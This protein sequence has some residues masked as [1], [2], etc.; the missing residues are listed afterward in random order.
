MISAIST[1][2]D[3]PSLHQQIDTLISQRHSE[4]K[5]VPTAI[6][7]DAEFIRRVHLDLNGVIPSAEVTRAFLEN[8]ATDKRQKLIDDL[9][10][11]PDYALHMAR[12]FDVMLTERRIAAGG[13]LYDVPAPNWREYLAESF[14]SNKPWDQLVRELLA[15]DGTDEKLASALKF[16]LVRDVAP[17]QLTRDVGRLFLGVDLQCAQCHDDPHVVDYRQ[18]DYF[19]IYAF[20]ERSKMHPLSPRGAQLAETAASKTTFVSVFTTRSGETSPR[21]PGGE[22]IADPPLEKDKEYLV[23]PEPKV[24]G[25]PTY[26][27]RLKLAEQLPRAGTLGFTRNIANRLWAILLGRGLVHP[28]DLHH[29]ANPPSHPELLAVL[30]RWMVENHYD[31]KGFLREVA[32]SDTYQRSS[33]MPADSKDLSEK[34]F[35]VAPL[36]GLSAEQLRWSVLQATGRIELHYARLDAQTKKTSPLS[37][38]SP[39]PAW[40]EKITRNEALERQSVSLVAAFTGL[41]GQPEEGFQ[42]VVDQ[43][44]Y[45]RNST[46]LLP[47][48][49]ED[50]GTLLARLNQMSDIQSVADGLY[51]SVL[52]RLPTEDEMAEVRQL[53]QSIKTPKER[54]EPLQALLWGLLLSSEFR[55]NH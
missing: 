26:S 36:R 32:I 16:Y 23:K 15:G 6:C 29:A 31:I 21:L 51:L 53:L 20:L 43:A 40:K 13:N 38:A 5:V 4:L 7:S 10:A 2:A 42:P 22:M 18:S 25:V 44:L 12:L 37:E 52:S 48:L 24:R 3:A 27:R 46:K 28:L 34:S 55:L 39:T 47:I 8:S 45:L 14:A 9:L 11:S 1:A 41:P 33:L 30:E 49:Q 35:A 19:G 17:H 54:R 50:S